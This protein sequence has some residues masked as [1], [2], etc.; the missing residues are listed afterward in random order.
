MRSRVTFPLSIQEFCPIHEGLWVIE[1]DLES[2]PKLG[3]ILTMTILFLKINQL[4]ETLGALPLRVLRR[5]KDD[6]K[7]AFNFTWW[8]YLMNTMTNWAE[9]FHHGMDSIKHRGHYGPSWSPRRS[10]YLG[11]VTRAADQMGK[12]GKQCFSDTFLSQFQ[13]RPL[14]CVRDNI[15]GNDHEWLERD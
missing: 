15:D 12:E 1:T 14:A 5:Y 9:G 8:T 2:E 11:K 7:I 10:S 13:Q 3:P 6:I 4:A